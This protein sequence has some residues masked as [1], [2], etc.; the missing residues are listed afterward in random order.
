MILYEYRPALYRK[1]KPILLPENRFLGLDG[2]ISI[3][4]FPEDTA[5]HIKE[6]GNLKGLKGRLLYT[7]RVYLDFDNNKTAYEKAIVQLNEMGAEYDAFET[8][9][10][11]EHV[12]IRIQPVSSYFLPSRVVSWV[13]DHFPGADLSIYKP[14]GIIR[15]PDT[16]HLKTGK[17]KKP[18]IRKQGVILDLPETGPPIV[19]IK[20]AETDIQSQANNLAFLLADYPIEGG[21]NNHCFKI[22]KNFWE[23]RVARDVATRMILE[24]NQSLPRQLGWQEIQQ[25]IYSVYGGGYL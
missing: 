2:F 17:K 20:N 16:I 12:H 9:N 1:A 25:V 24:W 7:D 10:R 6:Q 19:K 8:G 13:H 22:L 21:R 18:I 4:G 5:K 11:G 3:W 14:S 23:L 15:L